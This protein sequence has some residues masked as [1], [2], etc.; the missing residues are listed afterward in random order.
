MMREKERERERNAIMLLVVIIN[1]FL[2]V[3]INKRINHRVSCDLT[4]LIT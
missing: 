3:M 2:S 1:S 4:V